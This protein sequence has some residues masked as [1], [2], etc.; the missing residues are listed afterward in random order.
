M[1]PDQT[2]K[3]AEWLAEFIPPLRKCRS[4]GEE[5]TDDQCPGCMVRER[6]QR[7]DELERGRRRLES[8][9]TILPEHAW[10]A[11]GDPMLR[12]RIHTRADPSA[13]ATRVASSTRVLISGPPR[14]GKTSLAVAALRKRIEDGARGVFVRALDF[15]DGDREALK[16]KCARAHVL[17]I[18]DLLREGSGKG[19][20]AVEWLIAHRFDLHLATWVT[21]GLSLEEMRRL[22]DAGVYARLTEEKR[23]WSLYV[24]G[25][26][27]PD[28][29]PTGRERAVGD[30]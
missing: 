19:R 2:P 26:E 10:A 27:A 13:V 18:D 24:G 15:A 11:I 28:P 1:Q 16:A 4:C 22:Y 20:D 17:V 25:F 30:T 5:S 7:E 21:T 8:L 29:A 12:E 3:V 23:V 9:A 14:M 6:R